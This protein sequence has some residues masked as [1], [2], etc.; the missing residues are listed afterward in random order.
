MGLWT[1][2]EMRAKIRV[3]TRDAFAIGEKTY[4]DSDLLGYINDGIRFVAAT[5]HT[6]YLP[7]VDV[8]VPADSLTIQLGEGQL[9]FI[10][11]IRNNLAVS[12]KEK[13]GFTVMGGADAPQGMSSRTM[14]ATHA[15]SQRRR[16][17]VV[18]AYTLGADGQTITI[19]P[20]NNGSGKLKCRVRAVPLLLADAP[21]AVTCMEATYDLPIVLYATYRALARDSEDADALALADNYAKE[22]IALLQGGKTGADK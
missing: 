4:S 13:F 22:A 3:N 2:E 21:T 5:D 14:A 7:T 16:T 11:V 8:P 12:V 20:I 15:S 18:G 9:E 19:W 6:A 1:L 17:A 10:E